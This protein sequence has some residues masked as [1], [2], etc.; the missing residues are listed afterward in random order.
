[1]GL[2]MGNGQMYVR[3]G[4]AMKNAILLDKKAQFLP[5]RKHIT[6]PLQIQAS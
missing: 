2:L 4:V 5:H 1:M 6:S 3:S